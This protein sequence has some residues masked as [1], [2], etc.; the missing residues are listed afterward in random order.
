MN[1]KVINTYNFNNSASNLNTQKN[2]RCRSNSLLHKKETA[3]KEYKS[4]ISLSPLGELKMDIRD[5][6]PTY[7]INDVVLKTNYLNELDEIKSFDK[8]NIETDINTQ[9]KKQ[10]YQLLLKKD[11]NINK[12][13]R[14]K[15][16]EIKL[17]FEN[18]KKNLQDQLTSIIKDS[19][20]FAKKN[21]PVAAMLPPGMM[22]FF[23]K[24]KDGNE[25][26][27][28]NLS[29]SNK[30]IRSKSVKKDSKLRNNNKNKFIKKTKNEFLS[31]IGVDVDNLSANNVSVDI[32]K[33]WNFV[34]KWAKGRNVDEILRYKVV[35]SIMSLTEQK[36]SEKARRMYLKIEKY[37]EFKKKER[38]AKIRKKKEEERKKKEEL[39]K[40]NPSDLIRNR[41]KASLSEPKNF[42]KDGFSLT[43]RPKMKKKKFHK[44]EEEQPVKR[45]I[46]K[47]NGYND[48]DEII[49]FI[50]NSKK[51]SQ[52]KLNK[53]HFTNI[54]RTKI[55]DEKL[56]R[57]MFK[58][59]IVERK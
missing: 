33:A 47:L 56:K 49:R 50:D 23:E 14:E 22:E 18:R 20:L 44:D 8:A 32:D 7:H 27:S 21:S 2:P 15:S 1:Q 3:N 4:R 16:N 39:K 13:C 52:S 35:N 53:N 24:M 17:Q 34:L 38:L 51:N 28:I 19:L 5:K 36:A 42:N 58:N 48:V 12:L 46:I 55:M 26:D 25:D 57:L 31:L 37:K 11:S 6:I 59:L 10:K 9:T 45:E 43:S 54:K 29:S 40:M 30:S 41:M